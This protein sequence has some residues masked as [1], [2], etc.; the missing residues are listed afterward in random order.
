MHNPTTSWHLAIETSQRDGSLA[1]MHESELVRTIDLPVDQRTTATFAP[2]LQTLLNEIPPLVPKLALVSVSVGPGSFTGLR[3][4]VTAAKTLCFASGCDL[5]AI[6]S[7]AVIC[8]H[9]RERL[10]QRLGPDASPPGKIAVCTNAYRKQV[11]IRSEP[12]RVD[13]AQQSQPSQIENSEMWDQILQAPPDAYCVRRGREL[14][15]DCNDPGHRTHDGW[16]RPHA[17]VLGQM[18]WQLHQAGQRDDFWTLQ[19]RY[20]RASAAEENVG[21]SEFPFR[22]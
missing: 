10:K 16:P 9:E 22:A 14:S 2:A 11:F 18:A 12:Y 4:G 1:L 15:N 7:L 5:V 6:D 17:T 3:I 13:H 19:P 20:L 21:R 8:Q